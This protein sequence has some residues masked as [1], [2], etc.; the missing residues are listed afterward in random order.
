MI[1]K[2]L[3]TL[4]AIFSVSFADPEMDEGV[5]VLTDDNFDATLAKHEF[6]LVEFYAPWCGHCQQLA[7]EYSQAAAVLAKKD[8]PMYLAKVDATVHEKI[9]Q[10]FEVQGFP[11]L[12]WFVNGKDT[13]YTGGRT[14]D[15]IVSWISKKTGPAFETIECSEVEVQAADQK[16]NLVFFGAKE[17]A[18]FEAFTS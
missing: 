10:R 8:P 16:L 14:A 17:G 5:L 18:L 15:T 4:G 3:L 6:L 12:K 2:L 7:P 13:E 1:S 11:T 9:G